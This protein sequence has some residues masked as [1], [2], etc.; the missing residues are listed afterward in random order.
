MGYSAKV[1]DFSTGFLLA[2]WCDGANG[3]TGLCP[4]LR[5][6]KLGGV[7]PLVI[8]DLKWILSVAPPFL[9]LQ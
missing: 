3:V 5:P 2:V 7:H 1:V 8:L 9:V 6:F 4:P